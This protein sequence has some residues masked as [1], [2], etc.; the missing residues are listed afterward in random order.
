CMLKYGG[1]LA[2]S[3]APGGGFRDEAQ[4]RDGTRPVRRGF[5]LIRETGSRFVRL[6][7]VQG[8]AP[9]SDVAVQPRAASGRHSAIDHF[10]VQGVDEFVGRGGGSIRQI[11]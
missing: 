5:E 4:V 10:A 11:E 2:R 6:A 7:R 8:L 9:L 1:G 3:V